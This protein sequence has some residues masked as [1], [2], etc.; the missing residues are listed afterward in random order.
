MAST[1]LRLLRARRCLAP[2]LDPF[3]SV[4]ASVGPLSLLE[5]P[6][7]ALRRIL[8]LDHQSASAQARGTASRSCSLTL[9]KYRSTKKQTK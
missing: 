8:S 7:P 4:A 2:L 1:S 9:Q 6:K 3:R 5:A